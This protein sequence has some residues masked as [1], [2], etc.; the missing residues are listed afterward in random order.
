[1]PLSIDFTKFPSTRFQGSKRKIIPWI[2]NVIKDLKFNTVLDGFGGTAS[3]SY[4]FKKMGKAVTYNDN[5]KFNYYI[6]KA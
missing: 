2:F 5:L 1:M 6:G 3:V 4:L